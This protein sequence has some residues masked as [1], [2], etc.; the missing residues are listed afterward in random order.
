MGV[1]MVRQGYQYTVERF[2][3]FT[4]VA[5]PGLTLIIPFID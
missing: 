2:G 4:Y 1:K 3:K 5:Q